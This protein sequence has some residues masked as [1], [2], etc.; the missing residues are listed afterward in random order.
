MQKWLYT[1]LYPKIP[2]IYVAAL[3]AGAVGLW[4]AL[5]WQQAPDEVSVEV[6]HWLSDAEE[7]DRELLNADL[8]DFTGYNDVAERKEAFFSFV[9][10]FV[11][12][13]NERIQAHREELEPIW[14]K[15]ERGADLLNG[16]E[17]QTLLD[18]AERYRV[19][20]EE[21]TTGEMAKELKLRVD[22]IPPSLVLAQ[23]ANESAW[24]TSRFAR[25]ANNLFGQ[26]CFTEGCGLVPRR[27]PDGAKHEV[28]TFD[29]VA[30]AVYAYYRNINTNEV[31]DYLRELRLEMREEQER[32]DSLVL[33]YGLTRYSQRGTEYI[34]ELQSMI[35][36]NDLLA[37]D[38]Q[39][40]S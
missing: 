35:R 36:F 26:W 40:Q 38:E 19:D 25:E 1:L 14:R 3:G 6:Q 24:G 20:V 13:E 7:V 10:S 2:V 17:R 30:D 37:L 18:F 33:A 34:S 5:N 28:K 16:E 32:L 21:M 31:Y 11:E 23:A 15:M 39:Y 9:Y 8:P 12:H 29:S 27:R 4:Q 22:L